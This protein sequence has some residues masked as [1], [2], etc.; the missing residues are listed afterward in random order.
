MPPLIR[1]F[2][3]YLNISPTQLAPNA[4]RTII[5]M[6]VVWSDSSDE[7]DS[8]SLEELLYYYRFYQGKYAGYWYL[9]PCDARRSILVDLPMSNQLWKKSFFFVFSFGWEYPVGEVI[10]DDSPRVPH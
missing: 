8:L 1:E 5:G 9:A 4:W 2:L 3:E 6:M 7:E 10:D